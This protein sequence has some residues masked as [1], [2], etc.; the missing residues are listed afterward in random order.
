MLDLDG[1][2]NEHAYA[3]IPIEHRRKQGEL[4]E[5][6]IP[7][8]YGL[9][10]QLEGE[11]KKCF[12]G[13][14]DGEDSIVLSWRLYNPLRVQT[15]VFYIAHMITVAKSASKNLLRINQDA[16]INM[17]GIRA[18]IRSIIQD[19]VYEYGLV[20]MPWQYYYVSNHEDG[21]IDV[22]VEFKLILGE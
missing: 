17:Y 3:Y 11:L 9:F 21:S 22:H 19:D 12:I 5:F 15:Y 14:V 16:T 10:E 1:I 20:L 2:L 18:T 13:Y 4:V 8:G 6:F 7:S